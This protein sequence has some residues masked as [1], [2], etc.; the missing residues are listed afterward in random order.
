MLFIG[1]LRSMTDSSAGAG[2][3]IRRI[4]IP[5]KKSAEKNTAS[6]VRRQIYVISNLP[7]KIRLSHNILE[8]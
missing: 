8:K 5:C 7:I 6:A 4:F 3:Q 1:P 2:R